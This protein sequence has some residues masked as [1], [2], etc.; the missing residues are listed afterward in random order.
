MRHIT[1]ELLLAVSKSSPPIFSESKFCCFASPIPHRLLLSRSSVT[2]AADPVLILLD[3]SA[4][5]GPADP[6]LLKILSS[7]GFQGIPWFSFSSLAGPSQSL[8]LVPPHLPDLLTVNGPQGS[9][10]NTCSL[11][12]LTP[13]VI[14]SSI[15]NPF[16]SLRT[17]K[18]ISPTWTFLLN[19][20]FV[21]LA[22]YLASL[23]D[24]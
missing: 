12:T 10:P 7:L 3:L 24:V 18:F 19:L 17:L 23:L 15:S 9:I 22:F 16:Y 20:R 5:S 2:S 11:S 13:L 14:L 4:A 6:S 8:P 21:C 1:K